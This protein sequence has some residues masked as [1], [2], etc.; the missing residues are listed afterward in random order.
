MVEFTRIATGIHATDAMVK[1]AP[2]ELIESR[3]I[4]PGK[5][6]SLVTGDVASVS[7]SVRAG[8]SAAGVDGVI[9]SFVLPNLHPQI[10]PVLKGQTPLPGKD[11][12][13]IL[14]TT[15]A[16]AIVKAADA[17]LKESPVILVRLHLALHIGGKGY[18]V[19]VGDIADIEA[20]IMAGARLAGNHLIE[21]T[22]IPNPY[23]EIYQ[24]LLKEPHW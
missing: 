15:C 17:A 2:V 21:H 5:Y 7:D 22:V 11:A 14:E 23:E 6:I 1:A 16:A 18:A 10:L 3:P 19:F 24:F 4:T 13:G 8:I 9:E 12:T 20:S